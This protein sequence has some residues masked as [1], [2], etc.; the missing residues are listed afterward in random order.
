[1]LGSASGEQE[2]GTEERTGL[3]TSQLSQSTQQHATTVASCSGLTQTPSTGLRRPSSNHGRKWL[4]P[5][6]LKTASQLVVLE[7]QFVTDNSE[8]IRRIFY[9]CPRCLRHP[10]YN[11]NRLSFLKG[12]NGASCLHACFNATLISRSC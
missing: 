6:S 3:A 12:V 8:Y 1:M 5:R 11:Q 2:L 4:R 10:K 9:N 7:Q